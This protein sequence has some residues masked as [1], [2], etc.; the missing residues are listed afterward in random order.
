MQ[1]HFEPGVPVYSK[2][3]TLFA[4][5]LIGL[6]ARVNAQNEDLASRSQLARQAMAQGRFEDAVALYSKLVRA[7]PNNP[8]MILNLGLALHSAGRFREA[9]AQFR[10]VLNRQ[11][12]SVPASL[13]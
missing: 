7:L 2:R 13:M 1:L 11:P 6:I 3:G 8:A 5:L 10:E 9:A 4:L 12:Q